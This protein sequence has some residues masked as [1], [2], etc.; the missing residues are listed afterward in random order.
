MRVIKSRY[1]DLLDYNDSILK[2]KH[3]AQEVRLGLSCPVIWLLEHKDVY[4]GGRLAKDE[5]L[6][7]VGNIPVIKVDRGGLHTYHGE[8]QRV[9]YFI[10]NIKE[11]FERSKNSEVSVS[12]YVYM[13][14]EVVIRSISTFGCKGRRDD[15]GNGV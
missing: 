9:C 13:L 14:E 2:M 7:D 12:D 5:H 3:I 4:T 10:I 8:G 15:A 11:Y 6:I 1:G